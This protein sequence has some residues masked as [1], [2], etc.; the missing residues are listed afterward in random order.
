MRNIR[1]RKERDLCL[2]RN[3]RQLQDWAAKPGSSQLLVKGS[4]R[5]RHMLRDFA[6]DMIELLQKEKRVAAWVLQCK[7]NKS[8][9][10]DTAHALKQV[11]YQVLQ[12]SPG[13]LNERGASL[14]AQRIQ[15]AS[16]AEDWF[17]LLGSVLRGNKE[18]YLLFDTTAFADE[19]QKYRW[20]KR[21][22]SLFD[23]LRQRHIST[24][25]RVVFISCQQ[26]VSRQLQADLETVIDVSSSQAVQRLQSRPLLP[27]KQATSING[28]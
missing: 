27:S 12:Q 14:T 9:S 18:V 26:A 17:S 3:S 20:T 2:L 10:F 11:V 5:T 23:E 21:L 19:A 8:D 24:T 25:M 28:V 1:R 4:F 6:A 15:D 16:S 22:A 7:G 13:V